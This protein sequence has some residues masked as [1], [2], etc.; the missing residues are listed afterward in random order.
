MYSAKSFLRWISPSWVC[1]ETGVLSGTSVADAEG[2]GEPPPPRSLRI[3]FI[4]GL[5]VAKMEIKSVFTIIK[6]NTSH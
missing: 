1:G 4:F 2:A 6:T 5:E 3:I